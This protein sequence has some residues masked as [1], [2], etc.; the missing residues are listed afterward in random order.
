M[1]DTAGRFAGFSFTIAPGFPGFAMAGASV[2]IYPKQSPFLT[3]SGILGIGPAVDGFGKPVAL[4]EV[5]LVRGATIADT[6]GKGYTGNISAGGTVTGNFGSSGKLVSIGGGVSGSIGVSGASTYTLSSD[7]ILRILGGNPYAGSNGIAAEYAAAGIDASFAGINPSSGIPLSSDAATSAPQINFSLSYAH[8]QSNGGAL[9][10]FSLGAFSQPSGGVSSLDGAANKSPGVGY[11]PYNAFLTE[12]SQPSAPGAVGQ[13]PTGAFGAPAGGLGGAYSAPWSGVQNPFPLIQSPN[14]FGNPT[15]VLN[16]I[17]GAPNPGV[18]PLDTGSQTP[19]GGAPAAPSYDGGDPGGVSGYLTTTP[20]SGSGGSVSY[21]DPGGSGGASGGAGSG[22]DQSA[23]GG[24]TSGGSG[25]W[26]SL[27]DWNNWAGLDNFGLSYPSGDPSLG[28]DQNAPIVLDLTGKGIK[29]TQEISSNKFFDMAGDGYQHQTAWA[30]AGNAVLFYDPSGQGALTRANQVVF[31]DWDPSAKNDMQALKDVFDTNHD[32][33]LDAGDAAY[34]NFFL[35]VTNANGTTSVETL[36]Q[37]GIASIN[38]TPNA[39]NQALPDG[40]SIDGETTYTTTAGKTGAA[41]TVTLAADANGYSLASTTTTNAD[42]STTI[43]NVAS[44]ASGGVAFE[45]ILN[46]SAGGSSKT[47][48]TL[49]AGGNV[50]TIQTDATVTNADGS[51]TETLTN[52]K[53]GSISS[54]NRSGAPGSSVSTA[55]AEKLNSTQTTVS[56]SGGVTTTTILRDQ[57]GGGWTTQKEVDTTNADGSSSI[58]VSNLNPDGSASQVTTTNVSA[59]GLTRT[60]TSLVDGIAADSTASTDATVWTTVGAVGTETV[61]DTAGTS[62]VSIATTQISNNGQTRVTSS[63]LDGSGTIDRVSSSTATNNADGSTTVLQTD[64]ANNGALIDA[65]ST[66]TSANGLTVT[67]KS[68]PNG[69]GTTSAPSWAQTEINATTL[70]TSGTWS[71]SVTD[72]VTSSN[73]TLRSTSTTQYGADGVSKTVVTDNTGDGSNDHTETV[74]LASGVTTDTVKNLSGNGTLVNETVTSTAAGGLSTTTSVD[75]TGATGTGGAPI[76]DHVTNDVTVKNSDGSSTE[77]ITETGTAGALI[78]KSQILISANGL[79]KTTYEDFTGPIGVADGSW[80]SETV[81]ATTVNA[82]NSLSETTTTYDGH[83]NILETVVKATSADRKTVTTTTT[84]GTTNLFKTVETVATQAKGSVVDTTTQFDKNGDVLGATVKTVSADGLTKTTQ[85]D[86]QGQTAATYAAS[87]LAFDSTTTS[88][89]VINADGSRTETVNATS[90]NGAL[91][92]TSQTTSSANGLTATTTSNPYATAHY[93]TKT[94]DVTTY[95][96]D[97]SLTKTVSAYNYNNALID[98]TTTT[99]SGNGL[100]RTTAHNYDGAGVEQSTTDVITVGSDGSRTEV[101]TDYTGGANGTV[102]D[103]TTTTSGVIVSGIGQETTITRQSAGSVPTYSVEVLAPLAN[104]TEQDTTQYYAT[105]GGALLRRTMTATSANG[106]EKDSYT[107]LNGDA[108]WDFWTNDSTAINSDGSKTR[109]VANYNKTGLLSEEV[110]K[111]SANGLWTTTQVDANGATSSGAPVFNLTTTD[112]T[113]LNSDGSRAETVTNA[114]ASGA[115]ISQL[116]KTTSADGQTVTTQRYLD[117]TGTIGNVDQTETVQTQANGSVVDTV[118]STNAASQSLGTITTTTSG[119]GLNKTKTYTNGSGATVDSQSDATTYD[120]NGDGGTLEDFEDADVVGSTT[121]KTSVKTQTAGNGQSR[122]TTMTL[123]GA[124]ALLPASSFSDV[125]NAA[126]S[127][128]DTG[129]ITKTITDKINGSTTAADTTTVVTSANGLSTTSSTT[130]AG[131]ASAFL[132]SQATT[133]TDGSTTSATTE[134]DPAALSLLLEQ[135]TVNTSWDG[136]TVSSTKQ[137]AYDGVNQSITITYMAGARQGTATYTPTFNTAYDVETN[138]YVV[139]AD[140][141]T[142]DTRVGTGSFNAPGYKQVETVVTNADASQTTTILNYDASGALTGQTVGTVSGNGLVEGLAFD[143][144]GHETLANLDA[145]AAALVSGAALPTNLLSTD[146]VGLDSVVLNPDGS[147]TTT[148]ET[149]YGGSLSNLRTES[150][151]TTSANGLVTT[152]KIDNNGNGVFAQVDTTTIAP[153]GSKTQVFAYYGDTPSTSSTLLG[154]DT[155]TTSA[156]G[157]V[158][159]MTTS[160][161]ITDTTATFANSNGSYEFSRNVVA[162]SFGLRAGW[163]AA[164][165]KHMIDAAGMDTWT[166]GNS[167]SSQTI[168]I[169]V[170]TEARDVAIANELFQTLLGHAMNDVQVQDSG[171]YIANGVFNRVKQA[172]DITA[173]STEYAQNYYILFND[174]GTTTSLKQGYNVI[175]ALEN[176]LGRLPTAEEMATFGSYMTVANSGHMDS[177]AYDLATA[178]VAIAQ[179]ASETNAANSV[180]NADANANQLAT[181]NVISSSNQPLVATSPTW[182]NPAENAVQI[183]TAGT[184]SESNQF[185]VD[186]NASTAQ[187]VTATINGNDDV[188]VAFN[189]S[190]LTVSGYNDSIDVSNATAT[191]TASGASIMVE[192]GANVT[193]SGNNDQIAQVGPTELTLSSGTGDSIYVGTGNKASSPDYTA[194]YSTTNASNATIT[195]AAGITDVVSGS[196]DVI[197]IANGDSLTASQA[198]INVGAGSTATVSGTNDNFVFK[199]AFGQE[200]IN[201]FGSTDS[202]S[203]SASDFANWS[204]LLSHTAQSGANTVITLDPSDTITLAGVT[205]SS[206]QASQFHFV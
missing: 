115:T 31:T 96:S 88:T 202:I 29:I 127:I 153:D 101:V 175:A 86:I 152:K 14:N 129:V 11:F 69:A 6:L 76:F 206:L 99:L 21:A 205:A 104:G 81:D 191:V 126:T 113:V 112:D 119:N 193:A 167:S 147:K 78:A 83:S 17:Y 164:W 16:G 103:V 117:A 139:N 59:N 22:S 57:L 67:T 38:L 58:V 54:S 30:G 194:S 185:I 71:R 146:I 3:V 157:L 135:T 95:N 28:N 72:S 122:A 1:T 64:A 204:A 41:A 163:S 45:R 155:Y 13:G 158:T 179:Y 39:V 131:G 106:L 137:S 52:Y 197:N 24:D 82:D 84:L 178:A 198:T 27:F 136:R 184:Y 7:Q 10:N 160:T 92:S 181:T 116:V 70:Y 161:G 55:G 40:S 89:T 148:V 74:S 138:T 32:G 48:T 19:A 68:D 199:P 44:Y 93:A 130:L 133:N 4:E 77:T 110:V 100:S 123:T 56:S 177:A 87:G 118:A 25:N 75:S 142:T 46:T 35:Q 168:T 165:S 180:K 189:G 51:T 150:V 169:N 36:A 79:T 172:Y 9:S 23:N 108:S 149:G 173:S 62:T 128:A 26:Q 187:G 53:Y 143:T 134:Y 195:L 111:T 156:N 73:G 203:L 182:I 159:T 50:E 80:D 183:G 20:P 60:T 63:S 144:T 192:S 190:N 49:N 125:V 170:K 121:L 18:V 166:W 12:G 98:Q 145:A 151:T 8:D 171:Q 154:T 107:A 132:V 141:S 109:T 102:R 61:T 2:T 90:Q 91:L 97:G 162:G 37:A 66:T 85:Q 114:S 174:K 176:A 201:G 200:V 186:A 94:T 34:A 124:L 42:G 105:Q 188:I 33:K 196:G 65:L 47:L 140:G 43:D 5:F 120:S 15:D